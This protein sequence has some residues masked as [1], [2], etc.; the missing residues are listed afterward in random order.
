MRKGRIQ[1]KIFDVC[2][3]QMKEEYSTVETKKKI[4]TKRRDEKSNE[5]DDK[6]WNVWEIA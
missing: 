1:R 5:V 4:N 6:W 3:A 2:P